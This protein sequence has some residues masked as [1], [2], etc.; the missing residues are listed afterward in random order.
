M[1]TC[2]KCKKDSNYPFVNALHTYNLNVGE[3]NFIKTVAKMHK[4]KR[5][6]KSLPDSICVLC[7]QTLLQTKSYLRPLITQEDLEVL[8]NNAKQFRDDR[9]PGLY[10][11]ASLEK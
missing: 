1:A 9:L 7:L 5:G 2:I 6:F 10:G 8:N 3:S 11:K 4:I